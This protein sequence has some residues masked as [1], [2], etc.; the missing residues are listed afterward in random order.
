MDVWLKINLVLV[1]TVLGAMTFFSFVMAPLIFIKLPLETASRFIRSVFPIYYLSLGII[2]SLA[3]LI[4]V[5]TKGYTAPVILLLIV[6]MLFFVARQ[7]LMPRI[8]LYRDKELD[9]IVEAG[10]TF[11]ILHKLSEL[12][13]YLQLLS[14]LISFVWLLK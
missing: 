5:L 3:S 13:N 2:S 4:L 7:F 12:I 6:A 1:A 10:R 11:K 14:V 8:N 9:G